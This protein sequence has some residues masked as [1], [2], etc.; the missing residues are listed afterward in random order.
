MADH[1]NTRPLAGFDTETTGPDA[2]TARIVDAALLVQYPQQDTHPIVVDRLRHV[3]PVTIPAGATAV[4]GITDADCADAP[5]A[6]DVLVGLCTELEWLTM[7]DV[8]VV[9]YNAAYDLTV[10]AAELERYSLPPL[11]PLTVIDPLVL[12][13]HFDRYRK[14]KRT[15]T[16]TAAHYGVDLGAD[17]HAADADVAA[18]IAVARAIAD[19]YGLPAGREDLHS[20]QAEAYA[21]WAKSFAEYLRKVGADRDPPSTVWVDPHLLQGETNA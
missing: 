20:L 12:D 9:I 11:P 8:P 14:G 13:R 21:T 4:H 15:L 18:S 7:D 10:L 16:A 2:T 19:R 6:P 5:E 1:I 3:P 17:A